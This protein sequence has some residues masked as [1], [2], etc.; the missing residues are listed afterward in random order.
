MIFKTL[1]DSSVHYLF[2][3][4]V[5]NNI[6]KFEIA[7]TVTVTVNYSISNFEKIDMLFISKFQ[8]FKQ[9]IKYE[10]QWEFRL[11]KINPPRNHS[12]FAMAM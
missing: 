1:Q 7:P 5:Q 2:N 10:Q 8:N 4:S 12:Q 3:M 9:I 11:S 6:C